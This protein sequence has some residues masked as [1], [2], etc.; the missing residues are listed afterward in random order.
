VLTKAG[1]PPRGIVMR[2][3]DGERP[4]VISHARTQPDGEPGRPWNVGKKPR[5]DGT[6]R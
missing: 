3:P 2:A 1:S 5:T 4:Q 6:S